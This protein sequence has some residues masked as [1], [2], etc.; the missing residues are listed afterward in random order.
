MKN[1][2]FLG[3]QLDKIWTENLPE[4]II[5]MCGQTAMLSHTKKVIFS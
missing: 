4:I 1:V 5:P 2:E 3:F